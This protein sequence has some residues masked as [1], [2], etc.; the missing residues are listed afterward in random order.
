MVV[1]KSINDICQSIVLPADEDVSRAGI[2]IDN[3][4]YAILVIPIARCV[5]DK[6]QIVGKGFNGVIWSLTGTICDI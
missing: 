5:K 6:S 4:C 3:I 1:P 2:V